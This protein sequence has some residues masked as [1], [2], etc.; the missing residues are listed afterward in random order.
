M[1]QNITRRKFMVQLVL[2]VSTV[3]IAI[4][5]MVQPVAAQRVDVDQIWRQVYEQ[6]PT[7]PLENQYTS[8]ETGDVVQNNTLISRFIRYHIYVKGR[9]PIY[10]FDWKISLADYLGVND[11]IEPET[12]PSN[13]TLNTNPLEGDVAA[14]NSL[15]R[16]QRDIL[17]QTLV[18]LFTA[19]Y[20]NSQTSSPPE[21]NVQP[22]PSQPQ[23]TPTPTPANPPARPRDPQPGDAQ[24]L[25]P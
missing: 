8:R 12:Y 19:A 10:R 24:L 16:T 18:D 15:D 17:V 9:P 21:P 20:S 25:A 11:F 6:L 13:D 4:G 23:L 1:M 22:R 14:I 5:F 2:L 3:L 7:L